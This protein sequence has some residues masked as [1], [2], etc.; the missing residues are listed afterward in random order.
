MRFQC[1][2]C[3]AILE[4]DDGL[5]GELV[6]CDKCSSAVAVPDT[7]T[8]PRA[9]LGEFAIKRELGQGGMGTV[10]LA[11]QI[12][13]DRDVALKVMMPA[14][15]QNQTFIENFLNEARSA[16][17]INHPNIVQA[18][19]FKCEG[20]LWYFAMEYLDG[21]TVKTML[22]EQGVIP[23]EQVLSIA[24]D[25]VA[26]LQFAWNERK[27][28]HRDI[29]P[30]NIMLN[31][32]GRAKLAD[33]GLAVN[34]ASDGSSDGELYGTPQ[35]VAPELLLSAPADARSDIY[36]L[37][38]SFY[39]MVT[40]QFPYDGESAD[41]IVMKHLQVPLTPIL[42]LNPEIP[43][44]FAV[45]VENMMCKR[46]DQRYQD[47]DALAKD[48]E[49]VRKG[50]MPEKALPA[51]AQY[52]INIEVENP[53]A[54]ENAQ[55][56]LNQ[57]VSSAGGRG[58]VLKLSAS[59]TGESGTG[60]VPEA[61]GEVEEQGTGGGKSKLVLFLVIGLVVLLGA[62]GGAAYAL[63]MFAPKE[64]AA[65]ADEVAT[66]EQTAEGGE[67]AA[68]E[69]DAAAPAPVVPQEF[70]LEQLKALVAQ[71]SDQS[72]DETMK[73]V[74]QDPTKLAQIYE[75][76]A[77]LLESRLKDARQ[78]GLNEQESTWS[79]AV[80]RYVREKR[81]REE[82][83]RREAE[84]A[85]RKR[86]EE[87][88]AAEAKAREEA[89]I[90]NIKKSKRE[91]L[92]ELHGLLLENKYTSGIMLFQTSF[93]GEDEEL[94]SWR[95]GWQAY[96]EQA[97]K[98]DNTVSSFYANDKS[99]VVVPGYVFYKVK[100]DALTDDEN[101][102]TVPMHLTAFDGKKATFSVHN[103]TILMKLPSIQ[104][105][106]FAK[107]AAETTTF[108][109]PYQLLLPEQQIA[110]AQAAFKKAE[111]EIEGNGVVIAAASNLLATG[112]FL[113]SVFDG[114]VFEPF[115]SE[116]AFVETVKSEKEYSLNSDL[117]QRHAENLKALLA[118]AK[119]M[120][121]TLSGK[122]YETTLQ[123]YYTLLKGSFPQDEEELS[124]VL[125]AVAA[126]LK[127]AY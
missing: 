50:Q 12:T 33:L 124:E 20:E 103:N 105:R 55:P 5:P 127:S 51:E 57:P 122:V 77:P 111:S 123:R 36:S 78:A 38:A 63:G 67:T 59:G 121:R 100:K 106:K 93:E 70:S 7:P 65:P 95:E 72:F 35:Y 62:G 41:D 56:A 11:H 119:K 99:G 42:E 61:A 23:Y 118:E 25:M 37:G 4:L 66:T 9:I 110:I 83:E 117:A 86:E 88:R 82:R 39:Q 125:G 2:Q 79:Y 87:A 10:Y 69:G 101:Y 45:L 91:R 3:G 96:V 71:G 31:S 30:D 46:P 109:M 34:C 28:I 14:L 19:A 112:N 114:P 16:A 120:Q 75:A 13:L 58:K 22:A 15:A 113:A 8:S 18:Y 32:S 116:S 21:P 6:Q 43:A 64:E 60:M 49:R 94:K 53:L 54:L 80:E 126:Y 40:G 76:V 85:K 104:R 52:P 97:E 47:Y 98:L 73:L 89:R 108:S 81:E 102:T 68:A 17:A 1:Q 24:T 84:E 115:R 44:G 26:A 48:L 90:A 27:I 29:K 74:M 107:D 92:N